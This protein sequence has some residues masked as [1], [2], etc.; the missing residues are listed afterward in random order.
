MVALK[1]DPTH[2]FAG[3]IRFGETW[4]ARQL[5][6]VSKLAPP[7]VPNSA[8]YDGQFYAQIALAPT[9]ADPD[10]ITALDNPAYRA[11]RILL[12]AV[13][14]VL[15][16]GRPGLILQAYALLNILCW[17]VLGWLLLRRL[18]PENPHNVARWIGCMFSMGVLDSVWQSLVD[19]PALLLL[20]LAL[21]AGRQSLRLSSLWLA[22]SHL[23][24][25]TNLLAAFAVF[26]EPH[27]R[28]LRRR[29]LELGLCALPIL[30]WSLYVHQR[31]GSNA[32]TS[33]L[34]NFTWPLVGAIGQI[35]RS[36]AE[37]LS[38]NLDS[39]H[40]FA[41][42]AIPSLYL[43]GWILL[44]LPSPGDPWWRVG[45]AYGA[46]MLFLGEWIWTGYWAACRA[47]LPLT[48][49]FNLLLPSGRGFWLWWSLG[50]L[51]LLHAVWRML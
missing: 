16:A 12:P 32:G 10:L 49:A 15:G 42:L 18:P 33:G 27:R 26:A 50:N 25:E 44:R 47:V 37:V 29:A 13:A 40:V 21:E 39:R 41:L 14:H 2:G 46:L 43:Q 20:V 11:R 38:G 35:G 34:G 8:G 1:F 48:I 31:F 22:L 45:L 23:A 7:V 30:A 3:L 36:G 24:K 5:P 6:A 9:L 51:T 4:A 17:F 28:D 19:L